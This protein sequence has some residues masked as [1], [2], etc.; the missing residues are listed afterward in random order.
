MTRDGSLNS[1]WQDTADA[2]TSNKQPDTQA[3]YDVVIVGG[4]ITGL[5]TALLLQKQ[6]KKCLLTEARNIG[7]GTT[8]GTTAHLNTILDTS[9]DMIEKK[10]SGDDARLVAEG[11]KEAIAL[12]E[13]LT[14]EH[15]IECSFARK[16]AYLYAQN[17]EEEDELQKIFEATQHAGVDASWADSIP[18]PIPFI[19]AA[20]FGEQAQ[21]HPTRYLRGI[22]AAFEEAGGIIAQ[23]CHVD[24]VDTGDVLTIHTSAGDFKAARLVYAT[25]I[26]PGINIFNFRCAPYRSYAAAF[27]LNGE[28]YPDALAYDM[29]D[30]Y[31]Y[32]RTQEVD[33]RKYL[34]AGGYDHKTGHNQNTEHSFMELEAY[35]KRYFGDTQVAYKW[36]SQYYESD[37]G[38][39]YIGPMPEHYNIYLA[40]G[41]GGNGITLGTLSGKIITDLICDGTSKYEEVF[42]P[43]RI[44]M[45]AGFKNFV[46]ENADV[47]AS[48]IK[49][50][51]SFEQLEQLAS[52]APGEAMIA[53]YADHKAGV[54]K[55]EDGKVFVIDP[56]CAHARCIVAWNSAEKTWDCPCHG[57]RYAPSGELLTGPAKRGL[58]QISLDEEE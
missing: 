26:P 50:R 9:Y 10:F 24:D 3:T 58:T 2:Y 40:T 49:R 4:G 22:A 41:F 17:P 11:T 7:F 39:P 19:K 20:R 46:K 27:T 33:D 1:L 32:F 51:F 54:Y 36:S 42:D 34:V 44:K 15:G 25:H 31:H 12:V 35:I 23:Q 8:G 57:A 45:V 28:K 47:V 14:A 52:L 48:F 13:A 30:P 6:G 56:V 21:M 37:D 16:A 43:S 29:K 38:L 53:D 5:T 55:N 18:V